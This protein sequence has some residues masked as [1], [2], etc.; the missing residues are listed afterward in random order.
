MLSKILVFLLRKDLPEKN[1]LL[2]MNVILTAL[3][4]VPLRAAISVDENRRIVIRGRVVPL[5]SLMQLRD[6]AE[7]VL[8]S[9]ARNV[10]HE[11]VRFM[12]IEKGYLQTANP[13]EQLFYKAALWV[14][15]EENELLK[16]MAG[17]LAPIE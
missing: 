13:T 5:E 9:Q 2:L 1:R 4:A 7:S 3:D 11:Q 16:Q 10:I 15:Q 8:N 12:A 17:T 14:M 6:S